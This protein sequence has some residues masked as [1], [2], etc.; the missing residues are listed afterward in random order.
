MA[1]AQLQAVVTANPRA[2]DEAAARDESYGA[3]GRLS[4]PL[5]GV[6]VLVKVQA[7]TAGLRTTFGS[8]LFEGYVPSTDAT[9]VT[10]LRNAG[11]VILARASACATSQRAGSPPRR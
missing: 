6:P 9:V 11:A 10:K 5:H 7:V 4:G 2:H 3:T 1:G 8:I